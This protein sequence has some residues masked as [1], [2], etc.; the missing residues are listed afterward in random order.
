MPLWWLRAAEWATFGLPALFFLAVQYFIT[1]ASCGKGVLDFP[2]G[3]WLVLIYTYALFIPNTRP[4]AAVAIGAM[5]FMP[6]ALLLGMMWRYSEVAVAV[7]MDELGGLALMFCLAGTGGVFGVDLI[8]SLRREVFEARQLGQYN[9]T[10]RI[11]AGG[12]GEVYLAE[13]QLLK[14]PCVVKLIRPDKT[15]N[16]ARLG[17]L[18]ARGP[19]HRQVVALEHDR[20]L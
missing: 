18:P 17:P 11:G 19:R 9:L 6:M 10:R 12:M 16:P 8:G 20:D 7:P 1:R 5:C 4:R 15:G 3:L 2:E 13:H 14:R